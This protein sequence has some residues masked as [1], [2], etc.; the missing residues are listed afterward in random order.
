MEAYQNAAIKVKDGYPQL[1]IIQTAQDTGQRLADIG[2]GVRGADQPSIPITVRIDPQEQYQTILGFGGA[3]TEA[4]AYVL[5]QIDPAQR[6]KV[7]DAY[8]AA[9]TGLNYRLCRVHMN[10]CDFSLGNYSCDDVDGDV[11]LRHF[12]IDRDRRYLVP[13]IKDAIRATG[14]PIDLLVTPWSPPAWMKT[15]GK[16]NGGGKLKPEYRET[17]ARFFVQFIREYQ[18]EG[19]PV[20]G[21]SVQ[22]EPLAVQTWDSCIFSA[23]EEA[24]FVGDY[25][26]PTLRRNGLADQ[27]IVIW[28][29][30]RDLVYD[31]AKISL[32]NPKAAQYVWGIG[33]HWYSG[34]Q[35][36]NIEKTY[37]EFSDKPLLFTEGCI[38]KGVKLGQWDRGEIYA[39]NILGDLNS[40][41]VGWIDWNMVLDLQGGPNH[42]GNYCDAPVVVNT[43]TGEVFFQSS[44]YYMGHFSKFI[45]RGARRIGCL[46]DGAYV[47][48][49]AFLNPD[50]T[51]V[52]V[53][54]NRKDEALQFTLEVQGNSFA[55]ASPGHSI[56]TIIL[57]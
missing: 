36:V 19:I 55:I 53:V 2:A 56:Q 8:F 40:G 48:L 30:N 47:E 38:E 20:W 50:G 6:Q 51:I 1:R 24:D 46:V 9:D 45:E 35:F 26:G 14:R 32:S 23:A 37:R 5:A 18:N 43:A 17:W 21:V 39:H 49:A 22:N 15:N 7:I 13:W 11:E 34:D 3:F 31:R 57:E 44:Y 27:K 4:G 10:S 41:T 54:L 12:N 28:D 33:F 25:L 29:H 42:A 52:V 16:M